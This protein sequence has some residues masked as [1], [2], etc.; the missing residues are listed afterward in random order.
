[1]RLKIAEYGDTRIKTRFLILPKFIRGEWRWLE[2]A[3]WKQIYSEIWGWVD[4][5]WV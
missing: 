2:I 1:M 3:S 4:K 5:E